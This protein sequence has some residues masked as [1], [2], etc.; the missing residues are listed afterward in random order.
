[1]FR[2]I[3][4]AFALAVV[5][6]SGAGS[7]ADDKP[8]PKTP[9]LTGT[10]VRE[11]GGFDLTVEFTGAD[12]V[13]I[14]A[15]G[16]DNGAE[17]TAKYTIDKKGMVKAKITKVKEIGKFPNELM[18]LEFSFTWK[19]KGDT[20]TLDEL[21]GKELEIAKPIMEGDYQRKKAPTP[22]GWKKFESKDGGFKAVVPVTPTEQKVPNTGGVETHMYLSVDS[23]ARVVCILGM[24][25]FPDAVTAD[26]RE[27][28]V[29]EMIKGMAKGSGAKEVSRKKVTLAGKP[30]TEVV[31]ELARGT[32]DEKG[33]LVARVMTTD[34]AAFMLII[35]S[36]SGR[37]EAKLENGFFDNFELLK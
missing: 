29:E 15:V 31:F 26:V 8:K 25:K 17:V 20:A 24:M 13:K 11:S 5:V 27:T 34:K 37:P 32:G 16:G 33:Q 14:R 22:T 9:A 6:A 1:M 28:V 12:T 18:G 35:G 10:W 2:V 21:T 3:A 36:E 30:A 23:D 19:V 4:G 7:H